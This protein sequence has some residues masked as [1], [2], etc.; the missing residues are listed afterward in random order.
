M[1]ILLLLLLRIIIIIISRGHSAREFA[2]VGVC[3][4]EAGDVFQS[5]DPQRHP[6]YSYRHQREQEVCRELG[7]NEC[8]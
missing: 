6:P 1:Y 4:E 2:S 8:K 3:G 5:A 7:T